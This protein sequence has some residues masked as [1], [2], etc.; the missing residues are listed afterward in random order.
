MH[1]PVALARGAHS[2]PASVAASIAASIAAS[3]A[4]SGDATSVRGA[5]SMPASI[6]GPPL[7]AGVGAGVTSIG[8][9]RASSPHVSPCSSQRTLTVHAPAATLVHPRLGAPQPVARNSGRYVVVL[10]VKR[11]RIVRRNAIGGCVAV[12]S[13]RASTTKRAGSS[14][15][16]PV[17]GT[18][19]KVAGVMIPEET[20]PPRTNTAASNVRGVARWATICRVMSRSIGASVSSV[21]ET[22]VAGRA[23]PQSAS[24]EARRSARE[25]RFM[26]NDTVPAKR[27]PV[28]GAPRHRASAAAPA[29]WQHPLRTKP[30]L[31]PLASKA[32]PP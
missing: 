31:A 2:Q 29:L 5:T 30:D 17:A 15:D 11:K 8:T 22:T 6:A 4:A 10:A 25:T 26:V 18:T 28:G 14:S 13:S 7:S 16:T 3:A 20:P 21:T 1:V 23:Q 27:A 32:P 24:A 9:H 12:P 19:E